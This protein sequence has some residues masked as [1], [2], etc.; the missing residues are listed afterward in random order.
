MIFGFDI[1]IAGLNVWCQP[2]YYPLTGERKTADRK[3]ATE[4][5]GVIRKRGEK[6]HSQRPKSIVQ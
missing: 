6:G 5:D 1:S 2:I 3:Q 4:N